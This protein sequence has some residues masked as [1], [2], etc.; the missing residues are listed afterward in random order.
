[1]IFKK[2]TMYHPK[3]IFVYVIL[4]KIMIYRQIKILMIIKIIKLNTMIIIKKIKF[5]KI[6]IMMIMYQKMRNKLLKKDL[7][8]N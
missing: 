8:L 6:I 5:Q 7:N 2:V 1:M 4:I 3:N